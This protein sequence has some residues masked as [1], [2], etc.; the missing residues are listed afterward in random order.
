[1]T[2]AFDLREQSVRS[3]RAGAHQCLAGIELAVSVAPC[4]MRSL[5]AIAYSL[6][7]NLLTRAADVRPK[8]RRPLVLAARETPLHLGHLR[9]MTAATE[10]GAMVAPPVPAFYLRPADMDEAVSQIACHR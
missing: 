4:S 3:K 1:M 9:A 10:A 5:S 8:E 6:F 2:I 7:D